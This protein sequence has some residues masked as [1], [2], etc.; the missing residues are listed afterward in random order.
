MR[1]LA[2][3]NLLQPDGYVTRI[4]NWLPFVP[5]NVDWL[6]GR[7]ITLILGLV[8]G[9]IPY[10]ILPLYGFLDSI[11]ASLL[12]AGRDLGASPGQTFLRVTL[13]VVAASDP[14][15]DRDRV[16]ADVRRLLHA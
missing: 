2:W 8:Y 3:I 11:G 16:P 7:P 9:Y 14:R 1:M 5:H 10:M 4:L 15:R 13:P 12:E 6:G